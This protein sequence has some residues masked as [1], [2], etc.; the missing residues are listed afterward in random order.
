LVTSPKY[1]DPDRISFLDNL[2]YLMVLLVVILHA[3]SSYSNHAPWWSVK[4]ANESSFFFDVVMVLLD[5]FPMPI[6]FFIAGYFAIPSYC[7][8]GQRLF[9]RRKFKRLG[10]PLLLMIP[11][12][13]PFSGYVY[14]YTRHG[15]SSFLSF[16]EYWL[17]YMNSALDFRI[18]ILISVDQFNHSH[19]WFMSL[20]L[21]FFIIFS[22]LARNTVRHEP[23]SPCDKPI[24]ISSTKSTL[25][26][27]TGVG[28]FTILSTFIADSI[29]AN[30]SNPNPWVSIANILQFQPGKVVSYTLYFGMGIYAFQKKWFMAGEL[31]G[32]LSLWMVLSILLAFCYLVALK[33]LMDGASLEIYLVFIFVRSFLSVVSLMMF[34]KWAY[35]HW[36]RTS[37]LD[38]LLA[39]NSY[40]MY[41]THFLI[42]IILQLALSFWSD[43]PVLLKFVIIAVASIFLS[44]AIGQYALKLYPRL[45][46][47][48][49]YALLIIVTMNF[50]P[51]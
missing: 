33:Q 24:E 27:L 42:V 15:Y 38:A 11:I 29:F 19:L 44:C 39:S 51:K 49:I 21:F 25:A 5:V 8:N 36:N 47:I 32:R 12:V 6:L 35:L 26:V 16:G 1:T 45:S 40:Y 41:I 9:L 28:F 50:N 18:K 46:V 20:L 31:P 17:D 34:T 37:R 13:S 48:G 43:G 2:R 3:A 14:H 23:A 30:P 4:E 7:K 10:L 22:V